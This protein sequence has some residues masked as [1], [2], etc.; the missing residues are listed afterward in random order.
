MFFSYNVIF[1][2]LLAHNFRLDILTLFKFCAIGTHTYIH[3][4]YILY[5][6]ISQFLCNYY[7]YF[8][9]FFSKKGEKENE[10]WR[11]I[12]MIVLTYQGLM[13]GGRKFITIT[14][15]KADAFDCHNFLLF[16]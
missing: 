12:M 1:L 16:L 11:M 9:A 7:C 14:F 6:C 4:L 8:F 13:A 5:I 15:P 10:C 2:Y 3:I